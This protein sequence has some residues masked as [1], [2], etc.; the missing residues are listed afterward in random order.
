MGFYVSL[1]KPSWT[2]PDWAFPAAWFTLWALQA[3]ALVVVLG[4]ERTGRPAAIG[5]LVAQ[6][7]AAVAWQAV[8]FGP[9]RLRLSAWWL[10]AV[11]LLVLVAI[12][13]VGRVERLAGVLVAPTLVWM[14]VATALGFELLRLN[15]GR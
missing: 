11:W 13:A 1:L 4:S 8:V 15:P 12:V 2:P 5:A 7:V 3:I 6:F 9:G 10:V 14:S